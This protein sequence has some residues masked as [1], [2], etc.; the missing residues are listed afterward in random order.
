[1]LIIVKYPPSREIER[2]K[3]ALAKEK[4]VVFLIQDG[5]LF[6]T[7]EETIESLKSR[8]VE[9]FALKEDFIARGYDES[10]S[11]AEL[12]NYSE[13]V[14]LIVEKGERVIG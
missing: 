11:F 7:D 4:D 2:R 1:M 12:V 5:V 3:M 9:V 14:D 8:G 13:A 6:A 10:E